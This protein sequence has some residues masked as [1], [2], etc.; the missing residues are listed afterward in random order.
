MSLRWSVGSTVFVVVSLLV[1]AVPTEARSLYGAAPASLRFD[2]GGEGLLRGGTAERVVSLQNQGEEATTFAISLEGDAGHWLS[3]ASDMVTVPGKTTHPLAITVSVPETAANGVYEALVRITPAVAS[4]DAEGGASSTIVQEILVPIKVHVTDTQSLRLTMTRISVPDLEVGGK[5]FVELDATNDGNVAAAP[6]VNA[7]VHDETRTQ[8]L[9]MVSGR[10]GGLAPQTSGRLMADLGTLTLPVGTYS[11]RLLASLPDGEV[12]G[13]GPRDLYF[14]VL[15]EGTLA[16]SFADIA[17][18]FGDGKAKKGDLVPI[19]ITF[20]N[21][22]LSPAVVG[23]KG[24]ISRDGQPFE[25][26]SI[27]AIET[28][29][30]ATQT[31]EGFWRAEKTGDY[32][33]TG[34]LTIG[35][36]RVETAPSTLEVPVKKDSPAPA[37]L[38][39]VVALAALVFVAR[40][41]GSL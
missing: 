16:M 27:E 21:T 8:Q 6:Q 4:H 36:K 7:I 3:V 23:F 19:R 32:G 26:F 13:G 29:T 20:T 2:G 34:A 31:L 25:T 22:G 18:A 41:R 9:A 40:R 10:A 1:A 24:L 14:D 12:S 39:L 11:I 5:L 33:L 15:P 35:P 37:A 28:A 30:G 38:S 17:V